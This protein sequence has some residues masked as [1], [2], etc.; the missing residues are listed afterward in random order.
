MADEDQIQEFID[1]LSEDSYLRDEFRESPAEVVE[2]HGID[3]TD[4][5]REKIE[6]EDW[7]ETPDDELVDK[8][9]ARGEAAWF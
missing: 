7:S 4:E 6:A 3:L 5:Q 8:L 1:R 9:S 2:R